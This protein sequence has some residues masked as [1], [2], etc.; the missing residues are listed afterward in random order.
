VCGGG[1]YEERVAGTLISNYN[2]RYSQSSPMSVWLEPTHDILLDAKLSDAAYSRVSEVDGW[3]QDM[4]FAHTHNQEHMVFHK[5]G[6]ARVVFRGTDFTNAEDVGADVMLSLGVHDNSNRFKRAVRTT[7]KVIQKYGRE[8][9]QTTGHSLGA[10]LAAHAARRHGIKSVGFATPLSVFNR[11]TYSNH[12]N[13]S[14]PY[15]PV[16][17]VGRRTKGIGKQMDYHWAKSHPHSMSNV[18]PGA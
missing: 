12:L 1:N 14:N 13:V 3:Q 15:D 18:I 11:R 5:H 10:G 7:E 8:N 6:K 2:G 16:A 9:T 17:W 4:E